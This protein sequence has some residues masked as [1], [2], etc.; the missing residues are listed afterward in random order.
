MYLGHPCDREPGGGLEIFSVRKALVGLPTIDVTAPI[1]TKQRRSVG[2]NIDVVMQRG[3]VVDW[4]F[5]HRGGC[6]RNGN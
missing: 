6:P 2:A 5:P 4:G 3:G 1:R